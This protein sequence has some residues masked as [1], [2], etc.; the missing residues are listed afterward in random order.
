M[1]LA[2]D[3]GYRENLALTAGIVFSDWGSDRP[4]VRLQQITT[5]AS[6]YEPGQFY[7][8][9]LPCI[10]ELVALLEGL[11]EY[12]VIDG[13][14]TLGEDNR[15]GLGM[16]LWEALDQKPAVIG[17]AKTRFHGTPA[18]TELLRGTSKAPLYVTS[19]GLPTELAKQFI[20][21][22]AGSYRIPTLLKQVDSDSRKFV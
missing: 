6:D 14:V 11:P 15:P 3:T 9:E 21:S 20:A 19:A 5:V 8:R 1:I 22:M 13:Y 17:V 12:I 4:D 2:V 10:L 16:K 18:A 7:R